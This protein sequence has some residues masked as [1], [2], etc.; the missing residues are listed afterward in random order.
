MNILHINANPKPAAEA[1]SKQLTEAFFKALK[2]ANPAA[3]VTAVDLYADPPP[4]YDYATYRNFWYPVFDA[5]FKPTAAEKKAVAYAEKH[6]RCFKQ[7]NLLVF[8]TPM[9]NFS[10]PGILKSWIDQVIMPNHTFTIG[11][12]GVKPLHQVKAIAVL[13]S[14]GG[15][16]EPGNPRD[17]LIPA[18]QAAFGFLGITDVRLAWAQGQNPFFFKDSAE[19]KAKALVE[20]AALGTQCARI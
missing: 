17:C 3:S 8:T 6:I 18:I 12:D 9:W 14:S 11:A 20:A 10:M 7:A 19:R 13:A 16:Y 1:N 5:S 15:A 2:Q 4:F